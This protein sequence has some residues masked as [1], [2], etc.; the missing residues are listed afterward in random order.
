MGWGAGDCV[1]TPE[2]GANSVRVNR[3]KCHSPKF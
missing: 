2:T 1:T 3:V